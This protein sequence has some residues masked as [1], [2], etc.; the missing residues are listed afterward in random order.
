MS[1]L[2]F[3]HGHWLIKIDISVN[4][5]RLDAASTVRLN[6]ATFCKGKARQFFPEKFDHVCTLKF[7]VNQNVDSNFLLNSN[8]LGNLVADELI[9]LCFRPFTLA[10]FLSC[11]TNLC[12][13]R[14]AADCSCWKER[15][16]P[17]LFLLQ[18]TCGEFMTALS[19]LLGNLFNRCSYLCTASGW[20]SSKL[21]QSVAILLEQ[22]RCTLSGNKTA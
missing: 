1:I 6:P 16:I 22:L 2:G 14:E 4:N 8:P 21:V 18:F 20:I 11:R 15:Q 5:R 17:F 12:S 19:R 10:P 13:L 9:I 3:L 7:T